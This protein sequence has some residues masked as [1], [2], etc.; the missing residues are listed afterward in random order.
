MQAPSPTRDVLLVAPHPD[1][2]VYS[3]SALLTQ[4]PGA[5]VMTVLTGAPRPA[6]ERSWDRQCGF[7]DSDQA[8]STRRAEDETAFAG[9]AHTLARLDLVEGPY[10]TGP[11]PPGD[12]AV[13]RDAVRDWLDGAQDPLL[14]LPVGA[15]VPFRAL[16]APPP[17][18]LWARVLKRLVGRPGKRLFDLMR[19]R[20]RALSVG[21]ARTVNGDHLWV[22]ETVLGFLADRDPS[23]KPV[24]VLFYEDYPYLLSQGGDEAAEELSARLGPLLVHETPV[25]VPVKVQW[26]RH[27]A[28]QLV[29]DASIIEPGVLPGLERTWTRRVL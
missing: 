11:R 9:T 23:R 12:T 17:G 19:R 7:R 1:D 2:A 22:R 27:Y 8:V 28:S 18:R 6:V 26:M 21:A 15:G 29:G 13:L 14:C 5:R 25:D 10:L 4:H 24:E 20:H 3:C 16:P